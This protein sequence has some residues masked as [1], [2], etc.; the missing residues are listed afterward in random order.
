MDTFL[1]SN[2]VKLRTSEM[3]DIFREFPDSSPC[4]IDLK[5]AL[6]KTK[7]NNYLA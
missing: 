3:I 1:Y 7:L 4:L 2:F 6:D 5:Y